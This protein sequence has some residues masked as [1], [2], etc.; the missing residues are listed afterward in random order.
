MTTDHYSN[1]VPCLLGVIMGN[2]TL[3][4]I[5]R[6]VEEKDIIIN[7]MYAAMNEL[8]MMSSDL[9]RKSMTGTEI[10]EIFNKHK[11]KLCEAS[12]SK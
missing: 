10:I 7:G 8:I 4:S 9:H 5:E 11:E 6:T 3:A 2:L 12:L 1:N